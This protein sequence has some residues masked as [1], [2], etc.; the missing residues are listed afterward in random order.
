M[1]NGLGFK[2]PQSARHQV[3]GPG[4]SARF[5]DGALWSA[6][7]QVGGNVKN[8]TKRPSNGFVCALPVS[9]RFY[10]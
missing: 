5:R 9:I 10:T 3:G 7:H 2:C 4:V 6:R 1:I 8:S